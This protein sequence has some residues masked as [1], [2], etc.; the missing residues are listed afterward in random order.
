LKFWLVAVRERAFGRD[1]RRLQRAGEH[2]PGALLVE[3]TLGNDQL[4]VRDAR[5]RECCI[6]ERRDRR[7]QG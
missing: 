4:A 7:V 1:V 6:G 3:A 2:E 5:S